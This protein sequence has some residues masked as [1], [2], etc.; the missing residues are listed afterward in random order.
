MKMGIE[1]TIEVERVM[2]Y[3]ARQR[4]QLEWWY[5]KEYW[6]ASK[7]ERPVVLALYGK[8]LVEALAKYRKARWE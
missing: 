6:K 3:L 7:E 8:V 1:G 5:L 2:D 4:R